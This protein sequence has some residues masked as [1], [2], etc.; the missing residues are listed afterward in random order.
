MGITH[1]IIFSKIVDTSD[2][3]CNFSNWGERSEPML[4]NFGELTVRSSGE[5]RDRPIFRRMDGP[6]DLPVNGQI[7]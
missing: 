2:L 4:V 3:I 5:W 1:C 6:S 7:V